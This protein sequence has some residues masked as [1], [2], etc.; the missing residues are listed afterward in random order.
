MIEITKLGKVNTI[1]IKQTGDER[2]FI[3][4]NNSVII[5]V[6]TLAMLL[7]HMLKFNMISP[8]LLEGLLEEYH[9]SK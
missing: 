8:K 7:K 3:S 9:S 6:S 1:V 2:H 4:T 5:Q